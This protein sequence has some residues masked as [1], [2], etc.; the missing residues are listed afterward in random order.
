MEANVMTTVVILEWEELITSCAE[1]S[2]NRKNYII[3][4]ERQF[5]VTQKSN[6][7]HSQI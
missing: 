3:Y 2:H 5:S 4:N 7:P 6:S 1:V